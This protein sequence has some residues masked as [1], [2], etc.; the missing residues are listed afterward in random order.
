QFN[1]GIIFRTHERFSSKRALSHSL[2][3]KAAES[4]IGEAQYYVGLNY[5][6]G[7]EVSID[8]DKARENLFKSS[9]QEHKFQYLAQYE[10]GKIYFLGNGIDRDIEK[11]RP[12]LESSAA[13]GCKEAQY[14]LSVLYGAEEKENVFSPKSLEF[15]KKSAEQGYPQAQSDYACRLFDGIGVPRNYPLALKMFRLSAEAGIVASLENLAILHLSHDSKL[16]DPILGKEY[17]LKAIEKGSVLALRFLAYN[18]KTG[19]FLERNLGESLKYY[20]MASERGDADS[21]CAIAEFFLNGIEVEKDVH[22][23]IRLYNLAYEQGSLPALFELACIYLSGTDGVPKDEKHGFE[24]LKKAVEGG[25]PNSQFM[26]GMYLRN[27]RSEDR[28]LDLKKS[29]ELIESSAKS[30]YR[31][32]QFLLGSIYEYGD[33]VVA[34]DL[35]ESLYWYKEA[36]YNGSQEAA[37]T[38]G[39]W[40][41]FGKGVEQNSENALKFFLEAAKSGTVEAYYLIWVVYELDNA[42]ISMNLSTAFNW[43]CLA[44]EHG[45]TPALVKF[46]IL[47]YEGLYINQ[48]RADAFVIFEH[49]AKYNDPDS[50]YYLSLYYENGEVVSQDDE[51]ALRLLTASADLGLH[52]AQIALGFRYLNGRGVT[53]DTEKANFLFKCAANQGDKWAQE[54]VEQLKNK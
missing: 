5:L 16:T 43:L 18:Y 4:G 35:R 31:A 33:E 52:K 23:G 25:E 8:L 45:Y 28:N 49:T 46:G 19:E 14:L 26:Y 9:E 51:E 42:K 34:Q 7:N 41:L 38:L 50:L 13:R 47:L 48:N 37:V 29:F 24:L 40:Y 27:R 17:L 36:F 2:L 10:L 39:T 53:K 1:L 44:V 21:T 3:E 11:A 15:L 32:S 22:E 54:L 12:L 30:G 20:R 6:E